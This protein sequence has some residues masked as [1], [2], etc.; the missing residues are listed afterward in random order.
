MKKSG[1]DRGEILIWIEDA[2]TGETLE[3]L[4]T[5]VT[6]SPNRA[7]DMYASNC[8]EW[9]NKGYAAV[10][11][12]KYIDVETLSDVMMA[13]AD[14]E[15]IYVGTIWGSQRVEMSGQEVLELL[16]NNPSLD[17]KMIEHPSQ[18][19]DDGYYYQGEEIWYKSD[20]TQECVLRFT[21][22]Q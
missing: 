11:K 19:G 4:G 9:D 16:E 8:Q 7:L 3:E 5:C 1:I 20:L 6:D 14:A 21:Q 10:L 17:G 18:G 13:E 22:S 15:Y 12:W 2:Q